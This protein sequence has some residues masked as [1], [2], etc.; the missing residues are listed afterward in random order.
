MGWNI[1]WRSPIHFCV[2]NFL[3]TV[4]FSKNSYFNCKKKWLKNILVKAI[5]MRMLL[6]LKS[7]QCVYLINV[8]KLVQPPHGSRLVF[9]YLF[10]E[11][12]RIIHRMKNWYVHTNSSHCKA[13]QTLLWIVKIA[14]FHE[15]KCETIQKRRLTILIKNF[16]ENRLK[17]PFHSL[18]GLA[19][20]TFCFRSTYFQL[21]FHLKARQAC[22]ISRLIFYVKLS[23]YFYN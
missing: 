11:V 1:C 22:E 19:V 10:T 2:H 6:F 9:I 4:S 5:K 7:P 12:P 16:G 21:A 18:S 17:I 20:H 15:K 23:A 13:W 14:E 8:Q 3:F